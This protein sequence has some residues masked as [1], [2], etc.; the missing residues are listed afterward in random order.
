MVLIIKASGLISRTSELG[1]DPLF[2]VYDYFT[3]SWAVEDTQA[4][5]PRPH[6]LAYRDEGRVALQDYRRSKMAN[7]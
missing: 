2:P 3:I 4:N 6:G 1:F 5:F 7:Y